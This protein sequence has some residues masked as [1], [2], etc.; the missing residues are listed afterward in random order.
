MARVDAAMA[1]GLERAAAPGNLS[2]P[3]SGGASAAPK[4]EPM[5]VTP[6][7]IQPRAIQGFWRRV[8]WWVLGVLLGLYYIGP[9]LRW[10]RGPGAPDQATQCGVG[11]AA[12][13]LRVA[14]NAK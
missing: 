13:V 2:L 14:C 5:Y 3:G 12:G 11:R 4:H 7:K 6:P 9:W 8:K 1:Q 10:D